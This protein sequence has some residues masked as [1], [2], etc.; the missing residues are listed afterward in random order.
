MG[1]DSI[2]Q[3]RLKPISGN[4]L[5][6]F[7]PILRKELAYWFKNYRWISQLIIWMSLTAFPAIWMTPGGSEDQGISY[8]TLFLWFSSTLISIGAILFSQGTLIEEKLT[9][10]LLWIFSK[11]LSPAGFILAKFSAYAV[12][13]GIIALGAPAAVTYL[14]A[15]IAGLPPEVSLPNYLVAI[16]MVYL[17]VL[18]NLASTLML[19]AIFNRLRAVSAIALAIC[20]GGA[21]FNG[22]VQLQQFRPYIV[23]SLQRHATATLVGQFPSIA[24]VAIGSTILLTTIF[25]WV[26]CWQINRYEF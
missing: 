10:T 8:L 1:R 2:Y 19:G 23:Y 17:V 11:P 21:V 15:A 18:F 7:S 26:S 12:F 6:G 13:L 14:I 4:G 3:S 22:N 9:Q 5:R 25:L 16:G 20:F 24:W